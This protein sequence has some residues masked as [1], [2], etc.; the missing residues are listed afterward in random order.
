MRST[1][2]LLLSF[3][4]N[5]NAL[6]SISEGMCSGK[7]SRIIS[8]LQK[9]TPEK[10]NQEIWNALRNGRL[11]CDTED[12]LW[13]KEDG[14]ISVFGDHIYSK[15]IVLEKVRINNRIRRLV[16]KKMSLAQ[17][18]F[19]KDELLLESL[20]K[21]DYRNINQKTYKKLQ[22]KVET[23]HLASLKTQLMFILAKID[24]FGNEDRSKVKNA[25][26][27]LGSSGLE[28]E[29]SILMKFSKLKG[30]QS[31]TNDISEAI[32]KIDRRISIYSAVG[33]SLYGLSLTSVL[34]LAALGLSI[35]FGLMGVIN[36]AHGEMLMLG[37]YATWIAQNLFS[38]YAPQFMDYYLFIAFPLGFLITFIIGLL[39]ELTIVRHLY[40][41]PLDS[42]LATW[43]VSLVLI[44]I[45]RTLAG[46]QNVE[47]A[48]P[49]WLVGGYSF[50]EGYVLPYN[51]I[52]SIIF[53]VICFLG[54]FSFIRHSKFGLLMRATQSNR[55][56]AEG[57]GINTR[58][59]DAYTFAIGSGIAGL[60]G[61]I[62]S[63]IGNVGP[64][65]GQ[66]YIID[67]FMVVVLGGVGDILGTLLGALTIGL[68]TKYLE[69]FTGAVFAKILVM[70]L[71]IIFIQKRPHGL[72]TTKGRDG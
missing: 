67:S 8:A 11:Y 42:L 40:N 66:T 59:V 64:S 20:K 10:L 43:G 16:Q 23:T 50:A 68:S 38:N 60:G 37:C 25:I 44:Q 48:S 14:F 29:R 13:I 63:Q 55:E 5:S 39:I 30:K 34:L 41:R 33:H 71:L 54:L 7:K 24:L 31:Y 3:L 70:M 12:Q 52:F 2:I 15:E 26:Q 56:M 27:M 4:L 17:L 62:L 28:S 46:A 35:T 21:L 36:M 57:L 51:R 18:D 53:S 72:V 58:K 32:Q 22:E 19:S 6:S 65:L 9:S 47:V 49:S 69:P 45:I 61:V 1:T